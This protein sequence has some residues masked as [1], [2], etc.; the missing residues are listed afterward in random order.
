MTRD[1]HWLERLKTQWQY[2]RQVV[3]D[4]RETSEW[5]NE[6]REDGS[7]IGKPIVEEW[8]CPYHNGRMCLRLMEAGLQETL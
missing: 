8:K 4:P 6:L 5:F 3:V 2:I 7:S 1:S